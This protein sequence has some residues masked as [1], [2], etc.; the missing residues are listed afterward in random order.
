MMW[1]PQQQ[2]YN[3]RDKRHNNNLMNTT[4]NKK[5]IEIAPALGIV[6]ILFLVALA[7]ILFYKGLLLT[8]TEQAQSPLRVDTSV[9]L[10]KAETDE[11]TVRQQL[12]Q[13]ERQLE[14]VSVEVSSNDLF[15]LD[16]LDAELIDFTEL[17]EIFN[18]EL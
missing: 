7:G 2:R 6:I 17:D 10:E 16:Q 11:L 13:I 5:H 18:F 12:A 14:E 15:E 8:K 4:E 1:Q 3:T 9:A